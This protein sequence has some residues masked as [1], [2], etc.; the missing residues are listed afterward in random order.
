MEDKGRGEGRDGWRRGWA[1]RMGVAAVAVLAMGAATAPARAAPLRIG[2]SD[3]PGWVAWQVAIEKGWFR[4]AGVDVAF[5]WF[6]YSASL[7]AY[8]AGKL[9]AVTMSNGDALV[10]G[11]GGAR[12]V[13]ILLTDYSDGNDMVIA[14]P[15]IRSLQEL[16]GRKVAVEVGL[17]EHL[18]LLNGLKKAGLQDG[19]VTLVNA[20]TNELPQVLASGDVAAVVA[21]QPVSGQAM[22]GVPGARPIYT[23]ADEPGLI[24]D[25]LAVNPASLSARHADWARVVKV[26][27]RVVGYIADPNTAADAVRIMAARVGVTPATFGQLLRGTHLLTVRDNQPR[28]VK[29]DGFGSLYGSS[30]I[31]DRFN[32]ANAVYKASQD[33]DGYIDA[34][35]VT[36]R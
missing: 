34:S 35:L 2:Y 32:V 29:R 6:D 25:A 19:D 36:P 1:R 23:S 20:R 16:K 31:A 14:R 27:D 8:A 18:L 26:W 3:W 21:W 33:V 17:L 5:E 7:D 13:M 4:E 12:S 10:T 28:F 11:A 30:R 24:Y 15:G 22:R 9:D